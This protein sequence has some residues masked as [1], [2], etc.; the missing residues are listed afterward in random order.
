MPHALIL[1]GTGAIG[2]ATAR[3]LLN[4]GWSV[5]V[6]GRN[7]ARLPADLATAGAAFIPA[8]RE[9]PGQLR[10]AFGNGADLLVDCLC[11]TARHAAM[12]VPMARD[13]A[14]TVMVSAKAV[15]VD[16]AGNH[17][18][19][20]VPSRFDGPVR[21]SQPT[22]APA[23]PDTDYRTRDGYGAS[24]VAAEQVL[25]DSGAPVSVLRP[26]KVH[27]PG[28]STPREWVFVKRA[29]D[30]RPAVFLA[31][32][33]R[34]VD[35]PTAAA[36]VAALIETVAAKPG[37]RVL[38][39]ADP[40]APHALDIARTIA[41]LLDHRWQ[42][43]LLADDGDSQL[44]RHPWDVPHPVMLDTTAAVEL[45]YTPVGDYATTVADTVEWL[46]A[47]ARDSDTADQ[48]PGAYDPYF[49]PMLD[50]AAEDRYLRRTS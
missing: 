34:G 14:S 5:N 18:N 7:P 17:A 21:E 29:L 3:R 25:L 19:S 16:G 13:V 38:N 6:T 32:R 46:A 47:T 20:P 9:D 48:L 10:A 49:G 1:G 12:L 24:K 35:Q 33:G 28:A 40:D 44:G 30:Q 39:S 4:A 43:V 23:G 22:M 42:E 31:R 37:R 2:R 36:N 50:Y 15:Y 41:R 8:D 45:G 27:G 11:Y 26:G